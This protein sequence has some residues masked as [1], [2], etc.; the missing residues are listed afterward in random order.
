M[1]SS[2]KQNLN[3][4]ADTSTSTHS[5]DIKALGYACETHLTCKTKN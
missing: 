2:T 3:Q 4:L 1:K 5:P